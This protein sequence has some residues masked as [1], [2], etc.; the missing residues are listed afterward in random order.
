MK[1]QIIAFIISYLIGFIPFGEIYAHFLGHGS[2]K[3]QGSGNIG[4]T[5]AYRVGGKL[6]G[7]L[8]LA[9]DILKGAI[10]VFLFESE[11]AALAAI[12]GHI[13]FPL[14]TGG[15]GIAT[16]LGAFLMVSPWMTLTLVGV[17]IAVFYWKKISSLAGIVTF[18]CFP[19]VAY[20]FQKNVYVALLT[21]TIIIFAHRSNIKRLWYKEEKSFIQ[22][23]NS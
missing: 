15:K 13:R 19:F 5:N 11:W 1:Q 18:I 21:S 6:L 23:P 4:A 2:L 12:M 16:A 3:K 9:S 10:C 22:N 17:W 8:T 20:I 14:F 7:I